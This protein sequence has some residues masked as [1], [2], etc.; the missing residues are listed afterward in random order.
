ME[1]LSRLQVVPNAE[2]GRDPDHQK[3]KGKIRRMGPKLG[4]GMELTIEAAA[5]HGLADP[6]GLF[7]TSH[8]ESTGQMRSG[9]VG[10]P[11]CPRAVT[12][13]PNRDPHSAKLSG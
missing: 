5:A 8:Q 7:V 2:D 6:F 11:V 12:A 13:D 10:V 3:E 9:P 4:Q 1:G